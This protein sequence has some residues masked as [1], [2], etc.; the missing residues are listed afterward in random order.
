MGRL[1]GRRPAAERS[2]SKMPVGHLSRAPVE[3]AQVPPAGTTFFEF[4]LR[5][6]DGE[7]F[8]IP[9]EQ[10]SKIL[11]PSKA[12]STTIQGWGDNRIKVALGIVSFSYEDAGIQVAMEEFVGTEADAEGLAADILAN[13]EQSTGQKGTV[14]RIT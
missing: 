11:R 1:F 13:I 2:P 5:R 3:P 12:T 10:M 4:L 9:A 7:W 6:S 14:V 8:D